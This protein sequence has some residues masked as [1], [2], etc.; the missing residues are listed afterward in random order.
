MYTIPIFWIHRVNIR[1]ILSKIQYIKTCITK[2]VND[3]LLGSIFT[4]ILLFQ[5]NIL[6]TWFWIFFRVIALFGYNFSTYV[7]IF[8]LNSFLRCSTIFLIELSW[9]I[10][11]LWD[12]STK[13]RVLKSLIQY[14]YLYKNIATYTFGATICTIYYTISRHVIAP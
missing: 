5:R 8:S 12:T 11:Y 9:M 2:I 1:N 6:L 13:F 3:H 14:F 7:S 4:S 10:I